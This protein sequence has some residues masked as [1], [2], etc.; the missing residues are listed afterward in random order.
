MNKTFSILFLKYTHLRHKSCIAMTTLLLMILSIG[1]SAAPDTWAGEGGGSHYMPG[2]RGDFA[3][4]L[5]GPKGWYLRNELVYLEGDIGPMTMGKGVYLDAEQKVWLN[6]A[7]AVYLAD[8]G[9]LGARFGAVLSIPLV[10]DASLSGDVAGP[11]PIK[12]D[13]SKTGFADSNVT[14][15][16]NWKQDNFNYNAGFTLFAPTGSYD[17][18]RMINLGRNYWTLNPFFAFTWLHPKRGHEVSFTAGY[19]TNTENHDTDYQSGDE[20]HFDFHLAQHFS[21]K[22]AVGLDGYYYKQISKDK[23]PFLDQANAFLTSLG[24]DS[25]GTFKGETFGLGPALK[26]T[27]KL[28]ERDINII[29]KWLH[30]LDTTNRFKTDT[31]MCAVAFKF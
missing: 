16:L 10:I 18:D 9:I 17:A 1:L 27:F 7:K 28:G 24:K 12:R 15:I 22:F 3:M 5:I 21:S 25:L 30:D 4:A 14:G 26:Y 8:S 31:T 11:V 2:T 29:V 20:F 13:G 6:T 23:G 19:M